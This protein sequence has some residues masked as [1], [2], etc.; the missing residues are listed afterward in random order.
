MFNSTNRIMIFLTLKFFLNSSI[1][2]EVI[3]TRKIPSLDLLY[4][5][6]IS[7]YYTTGK[8]KP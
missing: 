6:H 4:N 7:I 3:K 2:P 5:I 8:N 1:F